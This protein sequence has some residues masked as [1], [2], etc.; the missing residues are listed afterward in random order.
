HLP[1]S[2]LKPEDVKKLYGTA[3]QHFYDYGSR[4]AQLY[5][6]HP[7]TYLSFTTP[8]NS[9][10]VQEIKVS[11]RG[12]ALAAPSNQDLEQAQ[13]YLMNKAGHLA[14]TSNWNAAIQLLVM[15]LKEH[16]D[17]GEAHYQLAQAYAKQGQIDEAILEYKACLATITS[18][19]ARSS[20][21]SAYLM[22]LCV[23]GLQ[24]LSVLPKPQD[25]HTKDSAS[26]INVRTQR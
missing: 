24:R 14:S 21:K 25:P 19:T 5:S 9:L 15:R 22:Q 26:Q 12:P 20:S 13:S 4:A 18:P 11:Y 17:D 16:P 23:E 10:R 6:F 8:P 2:E 3:S 7:N 1:N